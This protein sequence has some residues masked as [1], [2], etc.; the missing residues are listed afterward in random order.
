M[1]I[2]YIEDDPA[3]V[4]LTSRS[5]EIHG[6]EF[7]LQ[8]VTDIQE[9]FTLLATTEYDVILSDYRLPDGTGLD[10]IKMA[11]ERGILT[12]VVLITNQE[13]IKTAVAAL[14]AG[15][16]DYV[17]KQSDYLL[18]LPIVLQNARSQTQFEKQ[19]IALRE[20]ENRYRNIF[21]NA[22]EGIFQSTVDGKF[23]S[24][25]PAMA[26][27][28]GYS[29]PE[30]IIASV[31]D[32]GEQLYFNADSRKIFVNELTSTGS[33]IKFETQDIRK[34]GTVI[35]TSINARTVKNEQG[36]IQCFEGF[37]SDITEQKQAEL[38]REASENKYK[39]F[40][41]HFEGVVFLDDFQDERISLYM[42]PRLKD[43]LGYTPEEWAAGNR[44]WENNLHPDDHDRILA[45]DRRTNAS[46][47]PFQVE[48][49]M[50]RKDGCYV[51]IREDAYLVR[52]QAGNPSYWH[53]IMLDI[54]P[55]KEAQAA[56]IAGEGSYRGLF[57]SV[58]QAIY[59]QDNL[60]RILDVNDGAIKMYGYPRE[61]FI[62]KTPEVL[63]APGK[64]DLNSL[65]DKTKLAFTGHPQE[66]EFW[67]IRKNGQIF[68]KTVS[69]N[70][71]TYFG[72]DVIIAV[73]QDITER[74]HAEESLDRQLKELTILHAT[75]V[76]G[77]QSN[78]EDEIISQ[79]IQITS[80]I[81][82]EV[83]GILLLN[84]SG[85][86]LIP[87]F[88]Y[89]GPD[90]EN[91]QIEYPVTEGITG[92]A[93]TSGR[94]IRVGDIT[95]APN[96]FEVAS[97]IR[98]G[99][100]VPFWVH[101]RIIGVFDVESKREN[102]FDEK[103][104]RLLNTITAGLGTAIEK[105]RLFKAEQAQSQREAAILDLMRTAASSLDLKQVLQSILIQLSK[106]IPLRFRVDPVT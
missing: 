96:Y 63:S 76:A 19:K 42:S 46:G 16:A 92:R 105:L 101:D 6:S 71:G 13:D 104:E 36:E 84:E 58:T 21:E 14:K 72:Q 75:S 18:R 77:S 64:N 52:D 25:N 1:K 43:V 66:F 7:D 81:F 86:T 70:K 32:I 60:G 12:A 91:W 44:L 3:H 41:E 82:N 90:V 2:L 100:C 83:C 30:E 89:I 39:T 88:S 59:I 51:W 20:S 33:V 9:A 24:V 10:V 50:R 85:D 68:P 79:V 49:R 37:L 103:D 54:T 102:A 17:V 53:G 62:G 31:T 87:H 78:S 65:M 106:I 38:D 26:K 97:G 67:G 48:Y 23:L 27:I 28:Y 61:Y 80:S 40:V 5:L 47:R 69:L 95:K 55:Q 94:T 4:E 34:D 98:S 11:R 73:A 15:A 22:V 57:N 29:S 99:L 35:W 8:T 93:V 45:E 56:L 74:K